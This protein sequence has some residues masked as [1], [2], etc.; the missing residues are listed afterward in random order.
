M[1]RIG[2]DY[3]ESRVVQWLAQLGSAVCP[4]PLGL[5]HKTV[6]LS[7]KNGGH[8][9]S[10]WSSSVGLRT[11]SP[12]GSILPLTPPPVRLG[13]DSPCSPPPLF[14]CILISSLP[15]TSLAPHHC[16]PD[17]PSPAH[18]G[19][20]GAAEPMA[21]TWPHPS[22]VSPAAA[23]TLLTQGP[24]SLSPSS[25]FLGISLLPSSASW[26]CSQSCSEN[27]GSEGLR[28]SCGSLRIC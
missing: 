2:L 10:K 15:I 13:K 17:L 23:G 11:H 19:R 24:L 16:H 26:F 1:V 4:P 18:L 28:A 3:R 8:D 7:F 5:V 14:A 20:R 21:A 22:A 25:A 9:D 12:M 27:G 6:F